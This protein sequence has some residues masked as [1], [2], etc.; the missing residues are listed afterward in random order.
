MAVKEV[1]GSNI[2]P[3]LVVRSSAPSIIAVH[4]A[5]PFH[6]SPGIFP[7]H[8]LHATVKGIY[9]TAPRDETETLV[10]TPEH[11]HT[12]T[13]LEL[14]GP[15]TKGGAF[16]TALKPLSHNSVKMKKFHRE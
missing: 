16:G 4:G 3:P 12:N 8:K 1:T 5:S 10:C 13:A 11:V 7:Q 14:Q 6:Y 2:A 9:R 15:R